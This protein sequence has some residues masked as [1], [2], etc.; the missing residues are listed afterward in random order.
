MKNYK[1]YEKEIQEKMRGAISE[2]V[3]ANVTNEEA[4]AYGLEEDYVIATQE[5]ISLAP[6]GII[7]AALFDTI[8]QMA[9]DKLSSNI[10]DQVNGYLIAFKDQFAT[11]VRKNEAMNDSMGKD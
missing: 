8:Q 7:L 6:M 1:D 3:R 10:E 5:L 2:V 4:L 11:F 9:G